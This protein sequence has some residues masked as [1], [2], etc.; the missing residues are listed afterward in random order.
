MD[1][2]EHLHWAKKRALE[3]LDIGDEAQA[4]QSLVSD[5]RDHP[6][7]KTHVGIELGFMLMFSGNMKDMRKFINGFN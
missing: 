2:A 7:L 1:R 3:Y 6:E 4:Y 5:L